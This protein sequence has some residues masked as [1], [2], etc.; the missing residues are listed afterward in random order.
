MRL[1]VVTTATAAIRE[2]WTLEVSDEQ[3]AAALADNESAYELL[4]SAPTVACVDEVLDEWDREVQTV[5]VCE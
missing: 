4:G 2:R 3:A 5:S 1:E